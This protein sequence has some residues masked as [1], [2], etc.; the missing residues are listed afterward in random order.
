MST[1]GWFMI[2]RNWEAVSNILFSETLPQGFS[3][4]PPKPYEVGDAHLRTVD[5]NHSGGLVATVIAGQRNP[6]EPAGSIVRI[7][8]VGGN[9]EIENLKPFLQ[10]LGV[11]F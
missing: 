6:E 8:V 2:E 11:V 1:I 4:N 3:L 5:I 7:C 10:K 9:P